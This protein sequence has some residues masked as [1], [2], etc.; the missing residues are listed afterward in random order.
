MAEAF[1]ALF[2]ASGDPDRS[3]CANEVTVAWPSCDKT[4]A[5]GTGT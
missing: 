3:F 2:A 5:G 4:V 1:F